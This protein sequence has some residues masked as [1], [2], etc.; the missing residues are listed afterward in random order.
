MYRSLLNSL[1]QLQSHLI[2]QLNLLPLCVQQLSKVVNIINQSNLLPPCKMKKY[3]RHLLVTFSSICL[4]GFSPRRY[5]TVVMQTTACS[6]TTK[7]WTNTTCK[8]N[9][10]A[11]IKSST[12]WHS[13]D[14]LKKYLK[15]PLPNKELF[16][17]RQ[18]TLII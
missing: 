12:T 17:S 1:V 16:S 9:G 3:R 11:I 13:L 18:K 14:R 10:T 4:N 7:P 6:Y 8:I 2:L 15:E 5:H